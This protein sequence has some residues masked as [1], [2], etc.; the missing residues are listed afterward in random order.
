MAAPSIPNLLS[1][2]G[3]GRGR[4]GPLGGRSERTEAEKDK[5]VQQ[6]DSDASL[7]RASAVALGYLND[8]FAAL[9]ITG[10]TPRKYPIINRGTYVRTTAIDI[11]VERFLQDDSGH[12]SKRQII[13][14]G[15]GSDTRF[16]RLASR[17]DMTQ[18]VYHELDFSINTTS[19]IHSIK[20]MPSL[21]EAIVFTLPQDEEL[22]INAS[23][24]RL[25][26]SRYNIHPIDLRNF[27]NASDAPKLPHVD[28]RIPTLLL[29][30]CCLCYL[31]PQDTEAI[32]KTISTSVIAPE[33]PLALVLY[34]PIRPFDAFGRVMESNLGARGIHLQTLHQFSTLSAQRRRCKAAG[35]IGGQHAAD[36]D[37]LFMNWFSAD[38]RERIGRCEMLDELEEWQLLARHYCITW[39]WRD[40]ISDG[41]AV[42]AGS[43][44]GQAWS[45]LPNQDGVDD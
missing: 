20:N 8:P 18:V 17:F 1:L 41:D 36:M 40:Q 45:D 39:A 31:A 43:P 7:S 35:F 13:S 38:E 42:I 3:R 14:L 15:A 24:D 19:K 26:S 6:T 12:T 34:E 33:I 32:L 10:E 9:F 16:F 21:M 23:A 28:P 11:L 25:E 22:T 44:F 4:G 37:F 30:E 5:I 27:V 29:S 2:R